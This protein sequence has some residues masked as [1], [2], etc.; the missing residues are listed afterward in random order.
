MNDRI[1]NKIKIYLDDGQEPIA[2]YS[3][4]AKFE[5]DTTKLDDGEHKLTVIANNEDGKKSIKNT[6]FIVRNG[7]GIAIQGLKENDT[8]DGKVS[9]L[10]NAYGA[11]AKEKWEPT[12]A[13]TPSP[14]PS[15]IWIVFILIVA[16]A[17]FYFINQW[18]PP[19]EFADTPTYRKLTS[20]ETTMDVSTNLPAIN[21]AD[22]YRKSC[23]SCHQ[24]NGQ[25]LTNIFPPLSGTD[26]IKSNDPTEHIKIVLFGLEGKTIND[27]KYTTPMPA[28]KDQLTDEEVAAV[29]NHERTSWGN[30]A[31]LISADDVKK[32]RSDSK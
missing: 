11:S 6:K 17:M 21:G 23:S 24:E 13:E 27:I 7:P 15:W 25:G 19:D 31:K 30:S 16:W 22:I 26:V 10:I 4:P 8:V 18:N 29:I 28:W 1:R 12:T 20:S 2:V 14:I 32:V 3:P 5:L 9:L